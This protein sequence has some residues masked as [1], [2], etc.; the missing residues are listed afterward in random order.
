MPYSVRACTRTA[1]SC[2]A[3]LR[4]DAVLGGNWSS[5]VM[6]LTVRQPWA[7]GA[8]SLETPEAMEGN[9]DASGEL[10]SSTSHRVLRT[11]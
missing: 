11:A 10:N 5:Q 4:G 1:S 7:S 2:A 9:A 6:R 3:M 8:T